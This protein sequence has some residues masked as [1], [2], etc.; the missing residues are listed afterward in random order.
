M[1][2]KE[3]L[4]KII[5]G[6]LLSLVIALTL[7]T[8]AFAAGPDPDQVSCM[9]FCNPNSP[10]GIYCGAGANNIAQGLYPMGGPGA[11]GHARM[12]LY[13]VWDAFGIAH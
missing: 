7:G 12:T 8:T 6:S 13:E 4:K 10:S 5:A 11:S 3:M 9:A 2:E 1:E